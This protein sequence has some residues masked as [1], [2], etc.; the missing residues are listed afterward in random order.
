MNVVSSSKKKGGFVA[1]RNY[2][3]NR[4]DFRPVQPCLRID[5]Q[6]IRTSPSLRAISV[7]LQV[8]LFT[9]QSAQS[10]QSFNRIQHTRA[11]RDT[12]RPDGPRPTIIG[13]DSS[14][15]PPFPL[16]M[17]GK[18]VSGFGR[19]SKEVCCLSLSFQASIS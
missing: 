15:E 2:V 5:K 6:L 9:P 19:G 17:K 8:Q 10:P 13:P 12:M 3:R 1:S 16:R 4:L 7:T 14:P 18:V 11:N